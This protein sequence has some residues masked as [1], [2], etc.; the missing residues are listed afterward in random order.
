MYVIASSVLTTL[1][2][3]LI[4]ADDQMTR[5]L[6]SRRQSHRTRSRSDVPLPSSTTSGNEQVTEHNGNTDIN[7]NESVETGSESRRRKV[8]RRKNK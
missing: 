1:G 6:A 7:P 2:P 4:E 8:K 3:E 5:E